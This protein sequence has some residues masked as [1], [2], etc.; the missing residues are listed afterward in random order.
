[1]VLFFKSILWY[2]GKKFIKEKK[3]NQFFMKKITS[4]HYIMENTL[5]NMSSK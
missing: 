4:L 1:M 3:T 2:L 5:Q